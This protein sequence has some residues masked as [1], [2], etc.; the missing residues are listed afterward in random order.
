MKRRCTKED[1]PAR[2]ACSIQH[3]DLRT[4][5]IRAIESRLRLQSPISL[6][7]KITVTAD[8]IGAP[9]SL[10]IARIE[11]SPERKRGAPQFLAGPDEF[12]EMIS[13]ESIATKDI[14]RIKDNI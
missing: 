14:N 3:G 7:K 1:T 11:A 2:G 6:R 9:F 4:K 10:T 8:F 13:S 12:G 5:S